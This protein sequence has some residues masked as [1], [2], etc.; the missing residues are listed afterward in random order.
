MLLDTQSTTL[1][2]SLAAIDSSWQSILDTASTQLAPEYINY[3]RERDDWLPGHA[4][5][6]SAFSL[7]LPKVNY[8][9]FGESPYPRAASANGYAFWDAAVAD[10]WAPTGLS[11][12]V[13]HATSLRNFIKML[14][15]CHGL[16]N[17]EDTSQTAIAVIDKTP[18]ITTIGELFNKLMQCG[19][20]L[21]NATLVL[22][23]RGVK[24]DA[25]AWQP[26]MGKVLHELY[27]KR[28]NIELILCGR[29]AQMI[30]ALPSAQG[31]R[32]LYAEHPY[33][34]SF[35]HNPEVQAFF[36]PFNLLTRS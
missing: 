24:K 29:V 4:A 22:S 33:N 3:L 27:A 19:F 26:F 18:L 25:K 15:V 35:I 23:Q 8:I 32:K 12:A 7:P 9:L 34:L 36:R 11:K 30:D 2:F 13:N 28:P 1:D 17:P 16:L 31:F 5:L 14:C 20:L 6:L 21:L 10:L